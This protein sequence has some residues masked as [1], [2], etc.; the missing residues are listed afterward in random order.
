MLFVSAHLRLGMK[1]RI[2]LVQNTVP[3]KTTKQVKPQQNS[4]N[5]PMTFLVVRD[6]L[7]KD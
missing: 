6:F 3:L 2:K 5:G 7:D 1:I 4:T